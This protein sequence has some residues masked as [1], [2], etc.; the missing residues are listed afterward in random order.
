MLE[1]NAIT[2]EVID[3]AM[4]VHAEVGPGLLES[5][6][7]T[8][9]AHELMLRQLCVRR[10]VSFPVT[11]RGVVLDIGY[12]IDLLVEDEVIV[13][14]KSVEKIAAIHVAQLLTYLKL[15]KR[16]VGLILNFNTPHMRSGIR[17][18]VNGL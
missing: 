9:L 3:S 17:R 16:R 5:A 11:Y 1:L 15:G 13:E 12:R 7:E 8:C 4:A 6:Y 10:Q 2:R 18:V 14:L